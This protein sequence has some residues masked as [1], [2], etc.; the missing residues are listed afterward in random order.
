MYNCILYN[1]DKY[2]K[3]K[4]FISNILKREVKFVIFRKWVLFM[5][6]RD[7]WSSSKSLKQ[8]SLPSGKDSKKS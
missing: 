4:N 1:Q 8:W 5:I 3:G 2:A 6:L 7:A